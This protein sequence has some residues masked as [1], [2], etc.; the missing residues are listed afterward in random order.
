MYS[1]KI[2]ISFFFFFFSLCL[3]IGICHAD[4]NY[5]LVLSPGSNS[6]PLPYST[7]DLPPSLPS[8]SKLL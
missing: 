3:N 7:S 4:L 5:T 2:A 6:Q 8:F 1:N